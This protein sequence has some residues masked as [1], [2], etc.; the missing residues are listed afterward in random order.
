M[1]HP[2]SAAW[3]LVPAILS[4]IPATA[5]AP[6]ASA[7]LKADWCRLDDPGDPGPCQPPMLAVRLPDRLVIPLACGHGLVLQKVVVPAQTLL[8]HETVTLGDAVAGNDIN[9]LSRGRRTDHVAG[10]FTQGFG[11]RQDDRVPQL[12]ALS[13]RSYY[14]G[15]YELLEHQYRM[16]VGPD[17]SPLREP[18]C[19]AAVAAAGGEAVS[20]HGLTWYDAVSWMRSANRWVMRREKELRDAG[21]PGLLPADMNTLPAL[22]LPTEAE[23]EYA[24]RGGSLVPETLRDGSL[25]TVR[26]PTTKEV[27]AGLLEE[28]ASRQDA[29][30][31][32]GGGLV[33]PAGLTLPNL[34]GMYDVIGGVAEITLDFYRFV[35]P[36]GV[37]HGQLGGYVLRGGHA[38]T[39]ANAL[40]LGQRLERPLATLSGEDPQPL[41]GMRPVLVLPVWAAESTTLSP[42]FSYKQWEKALV[43][44]ASGSGEK[45][46]EAG[47]QL[48][49]ARKTL[50]TALRETDAGEA[51]KQRL[52][53]AESELL[54]ATTQLN[55]AAARTRKE[56]LRT[57]VMVAYSIESMGRALT[58]TVAGMIQ[59]NEKIKNISDLSVKTQLEQKIREYIDTAVQQENGLSASFD[60]YFSS[61]LGISMNDSANIEAMIVEISQEME[62]RDLHVLVS[63]SGMVHS[64]VQDVIRNRK[65]ISPEMKERWINEIDFNRKK[66]NELMADIRR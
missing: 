8:Q 39:S 62:K 14:I 42:G 18:D 65:I 37:V 40:G 58:S 35:R 36:D 10:S 26:D 43:D 44:A 63:A 5:A 20:A 55:D 19:T 66:R 25:P 56:Q 13:G 12:G 16:F 31:P 38:Q 11:E 60:F 51:I 34:L 29:A 27:R 30:A 49:Q 45:A 4:C 7:D 47:A 50:A 46:G 3:L 33:P 52:R 9:G 21:K 53:Q 48:A 41:A 54:R 23:W 59:Y 22:R 64:H 1:K 32:V 24:A 28:V 6:R 15:K 61:I 57:T 17:G 2:S